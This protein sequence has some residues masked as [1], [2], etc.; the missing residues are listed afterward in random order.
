MG[1]SPVTIDY[2]GYCITT[3]KGRMKMYDAHKWISEVSYWAKG[4]PF[5]TFKISFDN[6]YCIGAIKD[7]RQ[8]AYARLITDYAT[9]GYLSDV[10]VEEA[11][12]G[13]G[14]SKKMMQILFE[15][16]WVKKLRHL[17]LATTDAHKLYTQFGF[18]PLKAPEKYMQMLRPGIY[19]QQNQ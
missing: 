13:L 6:S 9:F 17:A 8:V 15:Q 11:H 7:G 1:L 5:D 16:D 18:T 19:E 12:R 10:Y 2:N 4:I 14:I 3:D